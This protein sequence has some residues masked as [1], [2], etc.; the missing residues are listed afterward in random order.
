[1]TVSSIISMI[2]I[3]SIIVGGFVYFLVLAIKS[4]KSKNG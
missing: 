1:M 3:V 2:G 4:E